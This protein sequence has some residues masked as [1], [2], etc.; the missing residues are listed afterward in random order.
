MERETD[1]VVQAD[2]YDNQEVKDNQLENQEGALEEKV[3]EVNVVPDAKSESQL[4][5]FGA[6][7]DESVVQAKKKSM[8]R[9]GCTKATPKKISRCLRRMEAIEEA[10]PS[11]SERAIAKKVAEVPP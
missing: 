11:M 6:E 4:F 2:G 5:S 9:K 10:I 3:F 1:Q 7:F 8:S